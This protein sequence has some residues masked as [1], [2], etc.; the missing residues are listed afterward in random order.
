[1]LRLFKR[2]FLYLFSIILIVAAV[3]WATGN[4][5]L[6]KGFRH[7]YFVGKTG[8]DITDLTIF[9][10]RIIKNDSVQ[11][12][13]K[14]ENY[15]S[16]KLTKDELHYLDSIETASFLVIQNEKIIFEKYW[17]GFSDT[18]PTNSFS[19]AKSVVSLLIGIAL[20]EQKISSLDEPIELY[21]PEYTYSG[22]TIR[23]L[24]W[25]SSGLDWKES[26]K[27]P[28]S[29][30]A[31]AYYGN[32]LKQLILSQQPLETPG[33]YFD[34]MSGNS[35]LLAL[36]VERATGKTIS[37]YAE[38]KLWKPI[39]AE[40][41]AYWSLDDNGFEKAYCCLYAIPRDFAKI[42]QLMLN[43]GKWNGSQI[44]SEKYLE[45]CFSP[46]ST[47]ETDLEPNKRY[48]LHWWLGKFDEETFYH[49]QG[50]LGQYI[51]ILPKSNMVIVRTGRKRDKEEH[52]GL[53]IDIYRYIRIAKRMTSNS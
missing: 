1:M 47:L 8:P 3:L 27:N 46:A 51:I 28:F 45:E 11:L 33:K 2:F 14:D 49:A 48:G 30:N 35:A 31:K 15:N 12:W 21:F 36:I 18:L 43:K 52:N 19:M 42:G 24:L 41:T 32:D 10:T 25:M 44:I 53:P 13:G 40:H 22:I 4:E 26:G 16:K 23:H 37:E 7:T 34:Y 29:D 6:F 9:P 20:D 39:N 5:H 38:E 50:I 17:D